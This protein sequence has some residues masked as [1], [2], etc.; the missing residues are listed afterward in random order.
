MSGK[1]FVK[2]ARSGYIGQVLAAGVL[3]SVAALLMFAVVSTLEPASNPPITKSAPVSELTQPTQNTQP[4]Q[5]MPAVSIN[6]LPATQ[7]PAD[8]V[9][10]DAAELD[11]AAGN[12]AIRDLWSG[13]V[14]RGFGWQLHPL[15]KDWRYHNGLD[16]S[17]GEGQ[18]VPA[19]LSGEVV[20]MFTDKQ[21]GLTVAV[22]SG[23]Y[24]VYYGSLA[25]IAV[26]KN[27]MVRAGRP[28]G[29]MGISTSEPEPHLHLA[30]KNA[31]GKSIDPR[32][33]FPNIPN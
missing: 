28:I 17:G 10:A 26:N 12:L 3:L 31:E 2:L 15:Y 6:Q 4:E 13:A 25:S 22:R 7:P 24:T 16:I 29:S 30:L 32:E 1:I 23:N 9:A 8:P 27:N 18:I 20:D 33:L 14:I 21:Y 5:P 19:L 11:M